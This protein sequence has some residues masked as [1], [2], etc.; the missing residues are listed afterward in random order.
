MGDRDEKGTAAMQATLD[1]PYAPTRNRG[2][3]LVRII[4]VI[5][6]LV[7]VY[8]LSAIA[9]LATFVHWFIQLFTGARHSGITGFVGKVLAYQARVMTYFGLMF[10]EYPGFFDDG[11]TSP[12]R[13]GVPSEERPVNRLTVGLRFIWIIPAAIIGALLA[14]AIE[15]VSVVCWFAIVITGKMPQGMF[16]FLLK[17]HRYMVQVNAYA[18]LLTDTY[19]KYG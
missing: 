11:A 17:G 7:V 4:L 15:V 5:P 6:H 18:L 19:P 13:V 14:I 1:I 10:D 2:T 3:V 12:A 8:V 9:Q 16:D